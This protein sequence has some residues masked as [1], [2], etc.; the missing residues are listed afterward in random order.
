MLLLTV[1][2][3]MAQDNDKVLN[4]QYADMKK[5]HF[6]F[7]IGMNFQDLNITNNGFTTADGEQ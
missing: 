6:G 3:A 1:A 2:A 7:S 4:R 5:L